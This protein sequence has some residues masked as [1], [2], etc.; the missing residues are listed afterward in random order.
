[1][2]NRTDMIIGSLY[3]ISVATGG[4]IMLE[5]FKLVDRAEDRAAKKDCR[6]AIASAMEYLQDIY[7]NRAHT[8]LDLLE[9]S[10]IS[11]ETKEEIRDLLDCPL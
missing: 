1:M 3:S 4:I 8:T 2:F 6:K 7:Q 9:S 5:I 10:D 11:E